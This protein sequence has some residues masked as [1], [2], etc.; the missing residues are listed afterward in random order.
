MAIKDRT[1][2]QAS[3]E[4]VL[5]VAAATTALVVMGVYVQRAYQGY[6]F[7][8]NSS[9]GLQFDARGPYD[10]SQQLNS[11]VQTQDI[12]VTSGRQAVDLHMADASLR[13]IPGGTVA[14]G[15]L[16]VEARVTTEWDV[17]GERNYE[18]R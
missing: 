16:G 6:L 11:Y 5:L 14:A 4:T 7:S 1:S 12:D 15:S 10:E 8:S 3:V 18:A 17:S 2:G 9:H 13:S